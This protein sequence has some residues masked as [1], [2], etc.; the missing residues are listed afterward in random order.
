MTATDAPH[1]AIPP[2]SA[3]PEADV[4]KDMLR[5]M[6]WVAPAFV[7]AG[8]I[9]W[10][11][12]GALSALLGLALVAANF[13]AAAGLMGWG[14][15]T[16]PTVLGIAVLGGYVVRLG[17]VLG[18]LWLLQDVSWVEMVPLGVTLVA[19]HLGLLLWETKYVSLSLAYPGLKPGA[20]TEGSK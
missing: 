17:V 19:T 12:D 11:T 9:G 18:V 4:A 1:S 14:A 20:H 16:S 10:G 3:A 15:R 8:F 5:R 7:L 13:A 6:V 2:A